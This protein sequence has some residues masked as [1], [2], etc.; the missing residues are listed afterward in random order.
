V[1]RPYSQALS[2]SQ[3]AISIFFKKMTENP[4]PMAF[5]IIAAISM[6]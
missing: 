6:D 2:F 4:L 1:W 5:A 3:A